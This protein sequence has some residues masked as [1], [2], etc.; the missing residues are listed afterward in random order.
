M[1]DK[2]LK[3][4]GSKRSP[5]G[6]DG[7]T[8][9]LLRM[10]PWIPSALAAIFSRIINQQICPEV[11]RYGVTV[12]LHKGGEKTLDNYRPITLTPTISK[13]FHSI[14]AAWL[15]RALTQTNTIRT[16]IQKGFLMGISGAIEHDLVLDAA[17][18]EASKTRKSLS[19]M[20][21]DLKNAFGSVPHSRIIWALQRFGAPSWV[22]NYVVN[23]YGNVQTKLQCK[24][25]ETNFLQVRRGVL[26]GDTLSPLLFLLVMQ[27]ALDSLAST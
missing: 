10:L 1:V 23:F 18:Q 17:L 8:Y 12:L 11:W 4:K 3:G 16:T 27:V 13:I 24:P 25:W 20:L 2:V 26:Q 6:I 19:M 15:E 22:S 9:T 7:I 5:P 21:I 14:V